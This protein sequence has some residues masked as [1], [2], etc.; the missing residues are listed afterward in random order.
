[1]KTPK[2]DFGLEKPMRK[3]EYKKIQKENWLRISKLMELR[4]DQLKQLD[5]EHWWELSLK[6]KLYTFLCK[7]LALIKG[8]DIYPTMTISEEDIKK[9]AG[10]I[11][12]PEEYIKLLTT[13]GK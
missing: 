13:Y 5:P 9:L 12:S 11:I 6:D 3:E 10:N 1:M 8:N 2:I 4:I 7:Q